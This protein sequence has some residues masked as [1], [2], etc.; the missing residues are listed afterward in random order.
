MRSTQISAILAL[1][2]CSTQCFAAA[3]PDQSGNNWRHNNG[4]HWGQGNGHSGTRWHSP[5]SISTS[6]TVPSSSCTSTTVQTSSSTPT[7]VQSFSSTPVTSSSASA[8]GASQP[9]AASLVVINAG[10]YLSGRTLQAQSPSLQAGVNFANPQ[11]VSYQS[12]TFDPA[13]GYAY[14]QGLLVSAGG[15]GPLIIQPGNYNFEPL[16]CSINATNLL[17]S[18]QV[19]VNNIVYSN[20]VLGGDAGYVYLSQQGQTTPSNYT[21]CNLHVQYQY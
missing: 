5:Q 13:T 7:S 20:W 4:N 16:V 1:A 6:S 14:D 3:V 8:I 11:S 2:I 18:C 19:T 10:D 21:A 9:T 12:Y 15:S 17:L